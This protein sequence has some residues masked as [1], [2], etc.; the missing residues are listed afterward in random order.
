MGEVYLAR[1]SDLNRSVA[2][3]VL[4]PDVTS[5][6]QRVARFEQEARAASALNHPSVCVIH[7][8][9]RTE[10]G[11]RFIAMEH[12]EG[13]T[14]RTR[15]VRGR[16]PLAEALDIAIQIASALTA[17]HA[18][19]IVHRDIKPENVMIRR[20][21]LVKVLDFGLA[22]LT[23]SGMALA[24]H[25]PTRTV[26][27]TEPGTLVGTTRYMAPEQARGE[28]VDARTDVWALGVVLYEMVAARP[29]F[30]GATRSDVLA[31]ILER[32]PP[33][34]TTLDA[35]LPRELQRIVGKAL[36]KDPDERYQVMK[37]LL[38]DLKALQKDLFASSASGASAAA[39]GRPS[40]IRS[41]RRWIAVGVLVLA[42]AAALVW[43]WTRAG[44]RAEPATTMAARQLTRLTF[45]SGLQTDP[46]F[47]PDGRF[48][49]YASDRSGNFDIWV[50]PLAGG[51]AV[52]ITRHAAHERQPAW[53]P[54]GSTIAFRS[55]RGGGGLFA[56]PAL[57]GIERQLS[58]FGTHPMW[59]RDSREVWFLSGLIP[60]EGV[61]PTRLYRVS[62]DGSPPREE[63]EEFLAGGWWYWVAP[64]PDG[65]ISAWG[66]HRERGAGFYTVSADG[67][68]VTSSTMTPGIPIKT[69]WLTAL[70]GRFL[71]H[72]TG[73]HLFVQAQLSNVDNLWRVRID[74]ESLAWLSAERL[75]TGAGADVLGAL[76]PDAMKVA[77][78][79]QSE[80][81]RLWLFTR[82]SD[83]RSLGSMR[84]I[85]EEGAEA[86]SATLS[87]DGRQIAYLLR[88]PGTSR[89]E[90]WVASL[91]SDES[92][93]IAT[94]AD[95][96]V[97]SPDDRA[98]A[99]GYWQYR[100]GRTVSG[101][102]VVR[103]LGGAERPISGHLDREF[104][105][106]WYW[107]RA[108]QLLGLTGPMDTVTMTK[109]ALWP[110][111]RPGA[112]APDRVIAAHPGRPL[113]QPS[114]SP[115]ERWLTFLLEEDTTKMFV[116]PSEGGGPDGW[117]RIAAEHPQPDKPRWAP[118][119]RMLYFISRISGVRF[120][121][122]AQQFDPGRGVPVGEPFEVK[123]FDAPDL[124]ISPHIDRTG[125]DVSAEHVVLPMLSV[126]GSIWVLEGVG[127]Q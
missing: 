34:L 53:S 42:A 112:L 66:L 71:W 33:P 31:A 28:E 37:D 50:Q 7:A 25:E 43:W 16:L 84:P 80:S 64:H 85:T 87:H 30:T 65:R 56:V 51:D 3:K 82:E 119:G 39:T 125:I 108:G 117:I 55:E 1:D 88:R 114:L 76:S 62:I 120:D 100:D 63:L 68:N 20:D 110:T 111:T 4:P 11:R 9:G 26:H 69:D 6:P 102:L 118:D 105:W 104:F 103:E 41:R 2:V 29:P 15:L 54:D 94:N 45:G 47:S 98:V 79:T 78:G 14:L 21:R 44:D 99:Y 10:D 127:D 93:L 90:T 57:G 107:T 96:A 46:T 97:W 122:W 22:K 77:F 81:S 95:G 36:Q 40:A 17:A 124:Y 121:L 52:Q 67:T 35:Q 115:D 123:A 70:R 106:P 19:G 89:T 38:L 75:T 12:V 18:A 91:V 126:R 73:S 59:T 113:W 24:A 27:A 109:I 116:A 13:E 72:P 49:A 48:V 60:G 8:L 23:P 58:T 101:R 74:P 5:D 83:G 32:E 86:T 92:Q 61:W